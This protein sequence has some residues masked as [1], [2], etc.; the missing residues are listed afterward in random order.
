M[1]MKTNHKALVSSFVLAAM[2]TFAPS[3]YADT[4]TTQYGGTTTCVPTDLTIN[5][6]VA[7]PVVETKGG[8]QTVVFVENL[9][10]TD[11]TFAPGAD[12]LYR[13]IITNASNKTFNPVKVKDTLP[14]YLEFVSGPGTYDAATRTLAF[15][16]ENMTAGETR[17]VEIQAKIVD[18]TKFPSGKSLFCVTNVAEVRAEDRFDSDSAQICLQNGEVVRNLPVAGFNDFALLLPFAGVGLGGVAL[19]KGKKKS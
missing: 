9:T 11:P 5:K 2:A 17:T 4:C 19:L 7:K 10:T 14:P 15:E 12:V 13:L 16:L 6:Q 18:V 1:F 8:T 3:V